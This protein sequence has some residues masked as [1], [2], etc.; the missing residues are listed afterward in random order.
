[1]IATI[2]IIMIAFI[3]LGYETD[4]M[5]VRLLADQYFII[6]EC[7]SWRLADNQVSEDMKQELIRRTNN[8]YKPTYGGGFKEYTERTSNMQILRDA[9]RVY[10]NP[11]LKVKLA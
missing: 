2:A 9:F 10:R 3:W 11:R 5:R 4:W 6:G 7:C 8:G 1:M